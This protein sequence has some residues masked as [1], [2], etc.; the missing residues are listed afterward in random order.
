MVFKTY[1]NLRAVLENVKHVILV[2]SGK[3]GVGKSTVSTQLALSLQ[4][5]GFKVGCKN[6]VGIKLDL[7][8]VLISFIFLGWATGY[9]SL[10]TE[11]PQNARLGEQW[12]I[13]MPP[14]VKVLSNYFSNVYMLKSF[15]NFS[16]IPVYTSPEK[17]LGVM[18]IA[19]LLSNKD[20]PV[21]WRGPKKNGVDFK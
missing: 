21:V 4:H 12:N 3:G 16:W 20:D 14:R 13:P 17:T 6:Y 9:W 7:A 18:S 15:L 11:H 5:S 19:F 2:L 1:L 10:W 8:Q